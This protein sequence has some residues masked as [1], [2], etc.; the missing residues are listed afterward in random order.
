MANECRLQAREGYAA[1][2]D[3]A[4][5]AGKNLEFCH[6]SGVFGAVRSV[7]GLGD[8]NLSSV[9]LVKSLQMEAVPFNRLDLEIGKAGVSE[10]LAYKFFPDQ[11]DMIIIERAMA[12]FADKLQ[13]SDPEGGATLVSELS[14]GTEYEWQPILARVVKS[15]A[16]D[17]NDQ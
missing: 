13:A 11:A 10:Y 4:R 16:S 7:L 2:F 12:Q 1:G 14:F 6:E 15:K 3:L 17:S 8:P 9:P 5:A